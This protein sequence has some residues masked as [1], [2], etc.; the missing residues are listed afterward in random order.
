MVEKTPK[1]TPSPSPNPKTALGPSEAAQ[2][3]A[4]TVAKTTGGT[5]N[6]GLTGAP[7]GTE[8][9][10]GIGG[11][12][13][14]KEGLLPT[15]V[16]AKTQYKSGDGMVAFATLSGPERVELLAILAQIPGLYTRKT[17]PTQDY[18]LNVARSK[19]VPVR[20]EDIAALENV[21]RYA[22]TV[23]DD[24]KTAARYL[25]SNPEVAQGYFD[26]SGTK[27]G[28]TREISL[29]PADALALELEQSALDYLDTK[30]TKAEKKAYAAKINELERKRGG[31]LTALERNQL[32]TDTIQD[33]ARE[34]FKAEE[35]NPDSLLARKGALGA[36][37][38]IIRETYNDY[39]VPYNE[40]QIYKQAIGS[41]RSKQAL[42]NTL[43]KVRMQAEVSMPAIKSYIQ[44]G[45]TPREALGSYI[46]LY[47]KIYQVPENQVDLTKL[48][49]VYSGDKVMPYQDWQK[50]LYSL[51]EFTKTKMYQDQK[52]D[53]ANTLIRNFIG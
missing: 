26:I 51:P 6:R 38:N 42:E 33:K 35:G 21:M 13:P 23:G 48:A 10:K 7:I 3:A 39:G 4:Q 18:L 32:L 28:K 43:N 8:V 34:L 20:K 14:F 11:I 29:T 25:V 47:S 19:M 17:A 37:A 31:A 45:L 9:I 1:P 41:I 12:V 50:Y 27:A 24:Y 44:Q 5:G 2:I 36:T 52:L 16:T 46:N 22:D 30:V 15:R 40:S 53:D 49:P